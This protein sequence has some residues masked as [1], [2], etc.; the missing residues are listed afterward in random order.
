LPRHTALFF[1]SAASVS[2]SWDGLRWYAVPWQS[3]AAALDEL[4]TGTQDV[5]VQ[6]PT[7]GENTR[8]VARSQILEGRRP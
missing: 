3:G 5:A 8:N 1:K 4:E 6:G 7:L 2:E